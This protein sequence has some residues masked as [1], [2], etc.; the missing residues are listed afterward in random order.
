MRFLVDENMPRSLSL[1]ITAL[2]FAVEDV[3]DLG[4]Q[5][6]PGNEVF[7]AAI[8]SDAIII[9]R[10]RGFTFERA[11]PENFTAG[12]IFVNLPDS[13]SAKTISEKIHSLLIQRAPASLVGAV[14]SWSRNAHSRK[15]CGEGKKKRC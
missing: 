9:T 5:G 2:G 13:A 6:L 8:R 7:E 14:P 3:R 4:L 15:L 12:V 11:W 10:D 1:A